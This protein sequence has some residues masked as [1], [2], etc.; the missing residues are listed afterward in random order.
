MKN[1][2]NKGLLLFLSGIL[3]LLFYQCT[4]DESTPVL[5]SLT[6][7]SPNS[8]IL[9]E[10]EAGSV[11]P[12]T[13]NATAS[14]GSLTKL[15]VYEQVNYGALKILLDSTIARNSIRYIH[16]YTVP[17]TIEDS[18]D[19]I[20]IFEV[21]HTTGEVYDIAKRVRVN[22][23]TILET[24]S[25][26]TM[27]SHHSDKES[28]F[29][30]EKSEIVSILDSAKDVSI[31]IADDTVTVDVDVNELS[32]TLISLSDLE[33]VHFPGFNFSKATSSSITQAYSS[34]EKSVKMVDIQPND[35]YLFGRNEE[36][37][38]GVIQFVGIND[39]EGNL[40]DSYVFNVKQITSPDK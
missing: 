7:P 21:I 6:H 40:N 16:N 14:E 35:I 9:V 8:Q 1:M 15:A 22:G 5:L 34:G 29:N 13:F 4:E 11:V 17:K 12:L 2:K 18:T 24:Y 32:R 19:I 3:S 31:D 25:G 37:A 33:F 38:L 30:L 26:L 39:G 36:D 20:L 28:A 23:G 10:T 27:Y